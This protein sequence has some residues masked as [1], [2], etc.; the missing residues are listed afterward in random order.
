M[1]V[2]PTAAGVSSLA[3]WLATLAFLVGIVAFIIAL[4]D[5]FRWV[6]WPVFFLFWIIGFVVVILGGPLFREAL[7]RAELRRGYTT[8]PS[9][10]EGVEQVDRKSLRVVRKANE[11]L[12]R[13]TR[14][15]FL[16]LSISEVQLA[17]LKTESRRLL[18]SKRRLSIAGS[19][20]IAITGSIAIFMR[21]SQAPDSRQQLYIDS[22]LIA[23]SALIVFVVIGGSSQFF[24]RRNRISHVLRAHKDAVIFRSMRE[25][26]STIALWKIFP[27]AGRTFRFPRKN[28]LVSFAGNGVTFW[29]RGQS[30]KPE[31][32]I[33]GKAILRVDAGWVNARSDASQAMVLLIEV[34]EN[35]VRVPLILS[36]VEDPRAT[37]LS[38]ELLVEAVLNASKAIGKAL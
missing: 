30:P 10:Y 38:N 4:S 32:V 2:R 19:V 13:N 35:E 11:P 15:A 12:E 8:F 20:L 37:P 7:T 25:T 3:I 36:S 29:G 14:D 31:M 6:D 9:H 26:E 24:Y 21:V 17:K 23:I 34:Q 5:R 22:S 27:K 18:I 33:D 16:S 28:G 1:P